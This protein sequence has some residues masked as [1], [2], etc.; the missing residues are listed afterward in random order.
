MGLTT[1]PPPVAVVVGDSVIGSALLVA[2]AVTST[3]R[4][5]NARARVGVGLDRGEEGGTLIM[6]C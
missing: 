6:E 1:K 2:A 3:M 4:V 5:S